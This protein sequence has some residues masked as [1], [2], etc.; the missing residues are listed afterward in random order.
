MMLSIYP[1]I[2]KEQVKEAKADKTAGY[3]RSD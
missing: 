1:G 3:G 2:F